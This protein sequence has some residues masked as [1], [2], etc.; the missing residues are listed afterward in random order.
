MNDNHIPFAGYYVLYFTLYLCPIAVVNCGGLGD[1]FNGQVMLTGTTVGSTA[2]YEC[3]SGFTLV[4]NQERT[5]Q[6]DGSWSGMDP[7]CA[8]MSYSV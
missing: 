2:T 3:N 4:G 5:C 6:E 8:G 7:G 1:P